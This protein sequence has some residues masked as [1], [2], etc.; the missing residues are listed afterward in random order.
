MTDISA[1]ITWHWR[2]NKHRQIYLV[3]VKVNSC[4]SKIAEPSG[5]SMSKSRTGWT[6]QSTLLR[7][8][9][10]LEVAMCIFKRK[11]RL[12]QT[13]NGFCDFV[14]V[15]GMNQQGNNSSELLSQY[16]LLSRKFYVRV[17]P[18]VSHGVCSLGHFQRMSYWCHTDNKRGCLVQEKKTQGRKKTEML[19]R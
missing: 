15:W 12:K 18:N 14:S 11:A 9:A 13:G 4:P 3:A 8:G 19:Q 5:P 7:L 1:S 17:C 10:F 2:K 16:G 6:V